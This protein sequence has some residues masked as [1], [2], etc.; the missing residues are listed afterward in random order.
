MPVR[1]RSDHQGSDLRQGDGRRLTLASVSL[2]TCAVAGTPSSRR[3]QRGRNVITWA[4]F[5]RASRQL[6]REFWL[7]AVAGVVAGRVGAIQKKKTDLMAWATL[8][9][10]PFSPFFTREPHH[11]AGV[12]A[13]RE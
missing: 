2:F 4:Q 1:H 5:K 10:P 7:P 8:S 9:I 11:V 12:F 6:L 3:G 13:K